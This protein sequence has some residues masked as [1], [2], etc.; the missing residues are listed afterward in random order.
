MNFLFW[1][2][3]FGLLIALAQDIKRREVDNWLN[4]FL[5]IIGSV[6][7]IFENP[8]T[9]AVFRLVFF[10]LFFFVLSN[11][12]YYGR[13]FAGGDAKLLFAMTPLF[14]AS[15]FKMTF[16][17]LGLFIFALFLVGSIYGFGY[18][19]ILGLIHFKKL[20]KPLKQE[21][22]KIHFSLLIVGVLVFALLGIFNVLIFG[23][24]LFILFFVLLYVYAKAIEKVA[25]YHEVNTKELREG[26]WLVRDL[27]IGKRV[28]KAQFEGLSKEDIK[29]IQKYK[30]TLL[31]K[32]GLPFVPSFVIAFL[33]YF[34]CYNFIFSFL[35]SI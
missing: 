27:K 25:M 28:F 17:N 34:F 23:L 10:I 14:V 26:D 21:A 18:S 13:F 35:F 19:L 16:F 7:F 31:I 22:K 4:L 5:L 15:T 29:F 20:R 32:D 1:F 2:F 33:V 11:V 24:A 6:F 9:E 12:M 3:L 30:K 8:N